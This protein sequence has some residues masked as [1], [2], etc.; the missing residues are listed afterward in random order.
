MIELSGLSAYYGEKEAL[1]DVSLTLTQGERVAL[2]GKNGCGKSTLLKLVCGEQIEHTGRLS[3][4]SRLNISYVAQDTSFLSGG[5]I[6]YARRCGADE[7]LFLTILRKLDFER[8]QFEKDMA[9]YSAGQKKKVLLAR[10]LSESAHLYVWDEPLNFIDVISRM[11]IEALLTAYRPT[12][13]FVEHDR[14][15]CDN[16]ATR[17]IEL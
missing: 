17:I 4:A 7:T 5:L 12:M 10:S 2:C 15:F 13:L 6:E 11:Q 14:A 8:A 16:V 3:R 1:R 9:S